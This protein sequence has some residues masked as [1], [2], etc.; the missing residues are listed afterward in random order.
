MIKNRS[1]IIMSA[2]IA[3]SLVLS[4]GTAVSSDTVKVYMLGDSLMKE[5]GR[6]LKRKLTKLDVPSETFA[7]IGSG[8]ARLDLFDWNSKVISAVE[9]SKP[10]TIVIMMGA[11]D[12]QAMKGS[13]DILQFGTPEWNQEYGR[14]AGSLMDAMT[15]RSVK[16]VCWIGLPCMRDKNIDSDVKTINSVVKHEADARPGVTFFETHQ[17]FSKKGEYSDYIIMPTGMPLEV[18]A[19]DG[20]HFNRDGAKHLADLIIAEFIKR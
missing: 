12:N 5:V 7:S 14:R 3:A 9:A 8:L 19:A 2:I 11:N 13:V 16:Q 15:A 1:N 6:R 17:R 4:A 18:R 20:I 10:E